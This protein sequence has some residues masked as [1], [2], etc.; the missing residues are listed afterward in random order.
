MAEQDRTGHGMAW[1][2]MAGQGIRLTGLEGRVPGSCA[3]SA[4]LPLCLQHSCSGE[5]DVR[6]TSLILAD[7]LLS[8]K[9]SDEMMYGLLR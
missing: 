8:P 2:S 7:G 5:T 6:S 9:P 3:A 1:E 4:P